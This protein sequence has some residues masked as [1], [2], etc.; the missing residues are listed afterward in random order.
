MQVREATGV[1][2]WAGESCLAASQHREASPQ[3]Q[4]CRLQ[5]SRLHLPAAS[6]HRARWQNRWERAR[7]H[8]MMGAMPQE[9][10]AGRMLSRVE[11]EELADC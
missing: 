6:K 5:T 2:V 1:T 8:G 10:R 3:G 7:L 11:G 9:T 4:A